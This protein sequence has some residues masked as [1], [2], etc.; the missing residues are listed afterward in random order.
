VAPPQSVT[1]EEVSQL[2]VLRKM[3]P[4]TRESPCWSNWRAIPK[5]RLLCPSS[6]ARS[7]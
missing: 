3:R 1:A 5:G 6:E 4:L 7:N 2:N